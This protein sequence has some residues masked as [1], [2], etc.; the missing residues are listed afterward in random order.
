MRSDARAAE[1]GVTDRVAH[2]GGVALV[3]ELVA[4]HCAQGGIALVASHQPIVL[5]GGAAVD[6]AD[7]AA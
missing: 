7:F 4:Q 2:L 5:P 6:L 1:L 3:E